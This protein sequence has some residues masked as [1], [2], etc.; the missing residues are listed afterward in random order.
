MA[1]RA[2]FQLSRKCLPTAEEKII[3]LIEL[4][5]HGHET[6]DIALQVAEAVEDSDAESFCM[7]MS[8]DYNLVE[9]LR[10]LRPD[11]PLILRLRQ[12]YRC[13]LPVP[14]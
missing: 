8:L 4:K 14:C 5:T 6:V 3:L 11:L 1:E 2:K 10:E 12:H 9:A 13:G 7:F